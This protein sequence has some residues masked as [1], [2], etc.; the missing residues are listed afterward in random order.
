[1]IE[2][3]LV[4]GCRENSQILLWLCCGFSCLPYHGFYWG[5][6]ISFG[7]FF[8]PVS[9]EFDWIRTATSGAYSLCFLLLGL[10]SIVSGR[11]SDKFGPRI[12]GT[13]C[14]LLLGSAYLLK[15]L[16]SGRMVNS[17]SLNRATAL[18]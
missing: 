2:G 7:V 1:M 9:T 14:G 3:E 17:L 5:Y 6:S 15:A 18:R 8:K 12:V 16:G 13:V 11:L 10:F 4:L